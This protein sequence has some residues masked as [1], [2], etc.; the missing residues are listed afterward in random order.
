MR[1]YLELKSMGGI[2][3]RLDGERSLEKEHCHLAE[4]LTNNLSPKNLPSNISVLSTMPP[5]T[6]LYNHLDI[7]YEQIVSKKLKGQ[8]HN[9]V[10]CRSIQHITDNSSGNKNGILI[11]KC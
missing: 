4:E 8:R 5:H 1:A 3:E 7:S 2:V 10:N 6:S 11:C 9:C